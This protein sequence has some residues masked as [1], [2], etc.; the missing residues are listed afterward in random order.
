MAI[1]IEDPRIIQINRT[2]YLKGESKVV[3]YCDGCGEEIFEGEDIYVLDDVVLHQDSLCC[4]DYISN[5]GRLEVAK[6]KN[7]CI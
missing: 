7:S 1:D 6:Q 2:G 3:G 4:Q 5:A